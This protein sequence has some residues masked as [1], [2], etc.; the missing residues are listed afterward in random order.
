MLSVP[1]E[2]QIPPNR[3]PISGWAFADEA[4]GWAYLCDSRCRGVQQKD[5][6]LSKQPNGAGL[7]NKEDD[8]PKE[9]KVLRDNFWLVQ[10]L[11]SSSARL[12]AFCGDQSLAG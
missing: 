10:H 4:E 8:L 2:E 3:L 5:F 9:Q 6:W 12:S 11:V 1:F 7:N